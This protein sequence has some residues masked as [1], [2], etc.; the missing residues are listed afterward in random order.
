MTAIAVKRI[1]V[2][3]GIILIIWSL[4]SAYS[5]IRS[6]SKKAREKTE[7]A[8]TAAENIV[9]S[10]DETIER[11]YFG[12]EKEVKKKN[13]EIAAQIKIL[14]PDAIADGLNALL[15]EYRR[16]RDGD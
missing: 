3:A 10:A 13:A 6:A 8:V 16:E 9:K 1:L 7:S 12:V 11:I 15:G 5:D 2:A 4:V 14:S